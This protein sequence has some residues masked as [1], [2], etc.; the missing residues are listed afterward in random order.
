MF[1]CGIDFLCVPKMQFLS[2]FLLLVLYTCVLGDM[3]HAKTVTKVKERYL[4]DYS[5]Y[6]NLSSINDAVDSLV[7]DYKGSLIQPFSDFIDPDSLRTSEGREM[8]GIRVTNL[9]FPSKDKQKILL[10]YGTHAREFLPVESGLNLV[11]TLLGTSGTNIAEGKEGPDGVNRN[12]DA[13][14]SSVL[15]LNRENI[16]EKI[17]L[18]VILM[19][20]PDGRAYVE[21]SENYCWRGNGKGVDIDRNFGWE[22]SSKG[23]FGDPE[24]EEY[25]GPGAFSEKESS[26]VKKLCS[27]VS[28]DAAFSFHSGGH[29]LIY[30]YSDSKSVAVKR[31]PEKMEKLKIFAENVSKYVQSKNLKKFPHGTLSGVLNYTAPGTSFDYFAGKKSIP[32]SF[33]VEVFDSNLFYNTKHTDELCFDLFNPKSTDLNTALMDINY[34][35]EG[36]FTEMF[37]GFADEVPVDGKKHNQNIKMKPSSPN[38]TPGMQHFYIYGRRMLLLI[39]LTCAITLL[40]ICRRPLFAKWKRFSRRRTRVINLSNLNSLR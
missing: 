20:N 9:S 11:N 34:V 24:D 31:Y 14:Y 38:E 10:I 2:R 7:R 40:M 18:Y 26:M 39:W 30:P 29:V 15:D 25:A 19:L 6:H 16:L 3:S 33:T 23:R 36:L 12:I 1:L 21:K 35:Y 22:F 4:P 13:V 32:L 37:D 28:F 8:K 27:T 5:L 17:D